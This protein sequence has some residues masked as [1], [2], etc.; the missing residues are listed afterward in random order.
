MQLEGMHAKPGFGWHVKYFNVKCC[1][2]WNEIHAC[3]IFGE[4]NDFGNVIVG[5]DGRPSEMDMAIIR[6]EIQVRVINRRL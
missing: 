1:R 3:Y 4:K 6:V 5:R 2:Q